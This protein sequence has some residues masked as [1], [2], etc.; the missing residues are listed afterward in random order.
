MRSPDRVVVIAVSG[1]ALAQSAAKWARHVN[2]L[3]AFGDVDTRAIAAT[4]PVGL[5]AGIGLDGARIVRALRALDLPADTPIVTGSGFERV[6]RWLDRVGAFGRLCANDATIVAALKD[7]DIGLEL[8]TALG[9]PVP[10]TRRTPP[11][12]RSGWLSKRI[13]GAG[14]VHVQHAT[15]GRR[16]AGRYWQREIA[17]IPMS[18]TFLADGQSAHVLGFNRLLVSAVGALPFCHAGA[19][20]GAMLPDE[21]ARDL[22]QR[23]H[24]LVRVC[25]LRGLNGVDFVLTD[26]GPVMLEV[27]PRPTATIDLYDDDY[28][29]GLVR[30][31]VA[32]FDGP[33]AD[34][35]APPRNAACRAQQVIYAAH[36]LSVPA[37]TSLPAWC[38]DVPTPRS[39]IAGGAPVLSVNAAGATPEAALRELDARVGE[40]GR[41]LARWP[42]QCELT[43]GDALP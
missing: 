29:E 12:E 21:I 17:G 8:L 19:I 22:R 20:S 13:G 36:G 1:R 4:M 37:C 9:W 35:P 27:N 34:F 6:P 33:V 28:P 39:R 10:E 41:H 7:P 40:I 18:V 42:A 14:G 30:W 23:L 16:T 2:V 24:R 25:G 11:D 32:S 31:H 5:R 3:D 15:A 38:R 26:A 43:H